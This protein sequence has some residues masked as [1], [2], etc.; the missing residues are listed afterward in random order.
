MNYYHIS[1]IENK[2]SILATG[3]KSNEGIFLFTKLEQAM[4]I[5]SNRYK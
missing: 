5:A 2:E 3:L 4:H 1:P